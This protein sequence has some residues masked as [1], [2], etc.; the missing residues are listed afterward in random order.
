MIKLFNMEEVFTVLVI[1]NY[2]CSW[3]FY[4]RGKKVLNVLV[5][6]KEE[7]MLLDLVVLWLEDL[8]VVE[9]LL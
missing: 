4:I 7:E 9:T 6:E 2:E 1:V 3:K 5:V 8:L